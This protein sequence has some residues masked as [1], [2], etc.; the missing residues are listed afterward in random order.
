MQMY[1]GLIKV[2]SSDYDL[3]L[4]GSSIYFGKP[5]NFGKEVIK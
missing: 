5:L 2:E 4:V 3:I 1:V